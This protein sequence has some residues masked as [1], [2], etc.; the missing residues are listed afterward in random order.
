MTVPVGDPTP[1]GGALIDAAERA[2]WHACRHA[3][4]DTL[5]RH[6]GAVVERT[7]E[8]AGFRVLRGLSGHGVDRTIHEWPDVVNYDEPR[9]RDVLS[10]GLV[11]TI[12]PIIALSTRQTR[13]RANRWTVESADGSLTSHFEHTIVVRDGTAEVLT[14]W[15]RSE[16]STQP[17]S[18]L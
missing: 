4:P 18:R 10:D 17:R 8:D 3:Q 7:V 11:L 9:V 1:V 15:L 12:E 16:R 5:V 6:V 13:M 2:F 14:Q